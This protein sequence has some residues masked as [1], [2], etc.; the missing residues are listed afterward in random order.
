MSATNAA[1]ELLEHNL[2]DRPDRIAYICSGRAHAYR[3]LGEG[4]RC[5][6][7]RLRERGLTPGER[8]LITL[9]DCFAFPVAF[10]GCLLSGAVAVVVNPEF[11]REALAQVANDAGA[12][13][14]ISLAGSAVRWPAG[15]LEEIACDEVGPLGWAGPGLELCD[16]FQ[17]A[18]SDLAYVLYTSGSTGAPKGVPHRHRSLVLPCDL[19][20]K[21][22]LG[23]TGEDV[24]FSTSKCSF[25]YGLI[26]SLA[27]PLRL[28]ASAILHPGKPDPA[29][30][31]ELVRRHSP[32]VFFSV[33]TLFAQILRLWPEDRQQLPMRLCCS[34]GE[35]LPAVLFKEWQRL[36]GL[37]ILDGIGSTE[38]AYH[39]ISNTPGHAVAGSAGRL[40]P[41]YRARLVDERGEDVA[42]GHEGQ[43]LIDGPTR[44]PGGWRQ[45]DAATDAPLATGDLFVERDGFYYHRGRSDDM[46]KSAGCWVSPT[47]V[48]EV[49]RSHPVVAECAVVA[50]TVGAFSV[51]GAFVV[52]GREVT[53]SPELIGELRRHCRERLPD[54]MCPARIRF[55][56]VL[57]RTSTG[58]VQR[59]KLRERNMV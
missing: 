38:M 23:L 37:E 39:F 1:L 14:R 51:P 25:A 48:E 59:F 21:A 44:T 16:A 24:I 49:L 46:F 5:L 30:V 57:P 9:P 10:L 47:A 43:L 50:T 19:V 54:H 28:G 29:T 58:K 35:A 55:V 33:P 22:V 7:R 52:L 45:P 26:N 4:A 15:C 18:A 6:A 11:D 2:R 36:T 32:S 42:P 40:V 31:L 17:P 34:A 41:G 12:R 20:G 13:L 56:A 27:L 8:V 3:E 53:E